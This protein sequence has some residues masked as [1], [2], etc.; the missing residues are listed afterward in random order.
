M[1]GYWF[2]TKANKVVEKEPEE[3]R[4]IVSPDAELTPALEAEIERYRRVERGDDT[5]A[6]ITTAT[7]SGNEVAAETKSGRSR[8]AA[9]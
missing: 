4:Q 8:K 7:L 9:D 2:D 5:V 6:T 3:G 1:P